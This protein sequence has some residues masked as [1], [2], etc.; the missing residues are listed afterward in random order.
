MSDKIDFG[1]QVVLFMG[2]GM[3]WAFATYLTSLGA[4]VVVAAQSEGQL[5]ETVRLIEGAGRESS[6]S[7]SRNNCCAPGR[8]VSN[9]IAR[10]RGRGLP[11]V[12]G[13]ESED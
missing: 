10:R 13:K 3:G 12:R 6:R 8:V 4:K 11:S 1:G 9:M 7:T 2:R 5:V